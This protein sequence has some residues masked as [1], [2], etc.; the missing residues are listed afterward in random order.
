MQ[1]FEKFYFENYEFDLKNFIAKFYYSFD[2][3]EKFVEEINF[4]S[5]DF[6]KKKKLDI[7]IIESLIFHLF[8]AL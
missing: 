3:K 4:E 1:K 6:V 7:K 5:E 2:K 8:I